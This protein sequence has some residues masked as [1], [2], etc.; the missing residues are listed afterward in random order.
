[1]RRLRPDL[2]VLLITGYTGT[3]EVAPDL[4]R[5]DKPFRR[6]DLIDAIDELVNPRANI[7]AFPGR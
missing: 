5:L 7:V 1:M 4:P 3:A 6:T 2:P